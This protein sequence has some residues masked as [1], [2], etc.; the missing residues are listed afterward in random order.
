MYSI[1][2]GAINHP[3]PLHPYRGL[4]NYRSLRSLSAA[5]T[6]VSVV[7]PRPYAPPVGPYAEYR[8]IPKTKS[9]GLYTAHYPRFWYLLPKRLLYAVS[10]RSYAKRIPQ[11]I[12]RT[13]EIPA[14]VHACHIYPDGYGLL[15][16]AQRHDVPLFVVSHGKLLNDFDDLPPGVS[17]K[18]KST[19]EAATGVFCVSDALQR[20][21]E[22]LTDPRKVRTVPI[23]ADP[24]SFPVDERKQIR[25]T[26]GIDP[27]TTLVLFVGQFTD[28][29]GI[30]E[31]CELLRRTEFDSIEFAFIGH[32]GTQREKLQEAL[33]S[34]AYS[35]EHLYTGVSSET[36][37]RW[38]AAADLLLLPSHAEGRPTVIY[39]AMAS[40]TAVLASAVGGVPEQ[41]N[42]GITGALVPP[43]DVGAL[44]ET[45]E[46]TVADPEALARMG[47]RGFDR[48]QS[49]GWTWADHADRVQAIH[50]EAIDDRT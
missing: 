8:S 29:K 48:L 19:L 11:Y 35:A 18:I 47:R 42:D 7:S 20:K 15:P 43:G 33:E 44:V 23:G 36:L 34:S 14:V 40:K 21:A 41:V 2:A 9:W 24:E 37:Q 27:G 3:D 46:S 49:E 10:G 31:I 25:R 12:E 38:Y 13:L 28:R 4:F 5:G 32:G 50:M 45:L 1:I 39:E 26:L 30:P 22:Q 17:K 16:Y 6:N